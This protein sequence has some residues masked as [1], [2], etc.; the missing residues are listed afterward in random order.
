[1]T[2]EAVVFDAD[3]VLV[4]PWRF[5]DHL[6]AVHG[7]TP[8]MTRAFF[9]G[10]F[11]DCLLGRAD[12][13]DVLPPYLRAWG[14]NESLPAFLD[15]WFSIENAPDDDVFAIAGE[16]SRSGIPCFV[17]SNQERRRAAY[18][19]DEMGFAESFDGLFFSCDL[20]V[21]KPDA[22]FFDAICTR[23]AMAPGS[24]LLID[25]TP[26]NVRAAV[27]AGWHAE[28]FTDAAELRQQLAR[29]PIA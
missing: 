20:G 17:A 6:A 1:M 27:G 4:R 13:V 11:H 7:I 12:L 24:L 8:E 23:V 15:T 21:K 19:R 10:A 16:F 22:A 3:G 5:R 28:I 18:L 2:I 14:W 25:D 9:R 26:D 29:H